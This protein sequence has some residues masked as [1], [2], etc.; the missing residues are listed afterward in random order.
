MP[1][2]QIQFRAVSPLDERLTERADGHFGRNMSEVARRDLTRYYGLLSQEL[3]GVAKQLSEAQA[4]AIC[5]VM[6]GLH[7]DDQL[8]A[9]RYLDAEI[10]DAADDGLGEKWGVDVAALAKLV[11]GFTLVQRLALVDAVERWRSIPPGD[12]YESSLRAA[13]LIR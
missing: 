1:S 11:K 12:G 7:V 9:V 10:E 2:P 3:A 8:M 5:D 6:I 13:G 4:C